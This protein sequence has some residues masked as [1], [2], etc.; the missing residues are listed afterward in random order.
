MLDSQLV[1]NRP[2]ILV[3][4]FTGSHYFRFYKD[5]RNAQKRL[6]ESLSPYDLP[7]ITYTFSDLVGI[8]RP[9]SSYFFYLFTRYGVGGWFWKPI[10]IRQAL[11]EYDPENLIYVDSDCVF[12]K[13]PEIFL[14]EALRA[15]DLAFFAQR[16]KLKG[17]VSKRAIK[18]LDLTEDQLNNSNLVTA[19]I[20]MVKN[21]INS[22]SQLLKWESSMRDP[23]LLLHPIFSHSKNRHLHDQSILSSLIAKNDVKCNLVTTGFYSLGIE[24]NADTLLNSWIYTG[25]IFP[26]PGSIKFRTRLGLIMDHYSRKYYDVFKTLIVFPVHF[27]YFYCEKTLGQS[28]N[29]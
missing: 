4:T 26:N 22:K 8:L 9:F 29:R 25:N 12:T 1:E 28:N 20:V 14:L 11:E 21:S 23:R 6:S 27:A 7:L 2:K 18:I 16:N 5:C 10:I 3:I 13:D 17:W 19:G 24:S 15:H